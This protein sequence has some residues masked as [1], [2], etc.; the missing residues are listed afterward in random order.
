MK[1]IVNGCKAVII[2]SHCGN[3]GLE[4]TVGN[5]IGKSNNLV[6]PDV[7]EIDRAIPST[8]GWVS[9]E[10]PEKNLRRIDYDGDK[11]STWYEL[12]NIWQPN[13]IEELA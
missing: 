13:K 4:V 7:W 9:M 11:K 1:G 3:N 10:I 8:N 2:N 5:Y 6:L 12:R